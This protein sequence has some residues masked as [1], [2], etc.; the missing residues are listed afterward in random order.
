MADELRV[1]FWGGEVVL[2]LGVAVT[3]CLCTFSE[4]H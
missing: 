4:N 2:G 3:A 1:S